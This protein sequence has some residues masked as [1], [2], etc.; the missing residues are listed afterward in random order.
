MGGLEGGGKK[1]I[2]GGSVEVKIWVC[3]LWCGGVCSGVCGG[4]WVVDKYV[5]GWLGGWCK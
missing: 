1:R 3:G 5:V 2:E 4:W